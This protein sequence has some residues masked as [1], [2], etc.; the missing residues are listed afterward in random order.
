M[1]SRVSEP[2]VDSSLLCFKGRTSS[3]ETREVGGNVYHLIWQDADSQHGK[4]GH[5]LGPQSFSCAVLL[6]PETLSQPPQTGKQTENIGN[7]R[8]Q[9]T[10]M[11]LFYFS[12]F[13]EPASRQSPAPQTVWQREEVGPDLWPGELIVVIGLTITH[14]CPHSAKSIWQLRITTFVLLDI[15]RRGSRSR[16]LL[17]LTSRSFEDT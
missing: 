11:F 2:H 15:V 13:N 8:L 4:W 7:M 6:A 5:C 12:E 16:I 14:T 9:M 1:P 17:T 10:P 3:N